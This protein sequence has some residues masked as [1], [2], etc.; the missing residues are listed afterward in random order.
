VGRWSS[1]W[2]KQQRS[3]L[4]RNLNPVSTPTRLYQLDCQSLQNKLPVELE[5]TSLS[6]LALREEMLDCVLLEWHIWHL[7]S[8]KEMFVG[9]RLLVGEKHLTCQPKANEWYYAGSH[10]FYNYSKI[11]WSPQSWW[12]WTKRTKNK[13]SKKRFKLWRRLK[14]QKRQWKQTK[15]FLKPDALVPCQIY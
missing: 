9:C 2:S 11:L 1:R 15:K 4:Q 6:K 14:L 13:D 3:S 7:G 12:C 10:L 8:I 5:P